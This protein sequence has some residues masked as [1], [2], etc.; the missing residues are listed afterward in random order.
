MRS[1]GFGGFGPARSRFLP[2]RPTLAPE[3]VFGADRLAGDDD[4]FQARGD[5]LD[6]PR[7]ARD[8]ERVVLPSVS[9][10][11]ADAR[12]QLSLCPPGALALSIG[13]SSPNLLVAGA[14]G[15]GKTYRLMVPLWHQ[16]VRSGSTVVIVNTKGPPFT[17][18]L[19]AIARSA[20]RE[21]T[22]LSFTDPARSVR[23]NPLRACTTVEKARTVAMALCL[24]HDGSREG[25]DSRF[26]IE[27]TIEVITSASL[28]LR[29]TNP[30][31]S[32]IDLRRMIGTGDF[33]SLAETGRKRGLDTSGLDGYIAFGDTGSHNAATCQADLSYRT[34]CLDQES[35]RA[36]LGG[37]ELSLAR[38]VRK[39]GLLIVEIDEQRVPML[40]P[41]TGMFV[42]LL[43]DAVFTHASR[44]PGG[45]LA[46][47]LYVMLNELPALGRVPYLGRYLNTAR[48]RGVRVIAD[49][50]SLSQLTDR[51]GGEAETVL[52]GF[53]NLIALG[54]GLDEPTAT[55]VSRRSGTT[56]VRVPG[57]M[58]TIDP[59]L[60]K[61]TDATKTWSVQGRPL[62]LPSEIARPGAYPG[63][64]HPATV[65]PGDGT[66]PFYAFF[67]LAYLQPELA[68]L[69]ASADRDPEP[70]RPPRRERPARARPTPAPSA[71][72]PDVAAA[73]AE[74]DAP[75]TDAPSADE[76]AGPPAMEAF[77][78]TLVHTT[79]SERDRAT[80]R[81]RPLTRRP[82]GWD[83]AD[84]ATRE[85]WDEVV[86]MH[87]LRR[88][89]LRQIVSVMRR[90]GIT[91]D[92]LVESIR[93]TG[94][95]HLGSSL[96]H[97]WYRVHR[98]LFEPADGAPMPDE[99]GPPVL[100][101]VPDAQ[102][103][104]IVDFRMGDD[105][106]DIPF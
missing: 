16:L 69:I 98:K 84:V 37:S 43:F 58:E 103:D 79:L 32:L 99:N 91:L 94:V 3:M 11:V 88:R 39:G 33:R 17:R 82:P 106:D 74:P 5:L 80:D 67:P 38:F 56:S 59:T 1:D 29:R 42:G 45:R 52:A 100:P 90:Q 50:Q 53:Q 64:G 104:G 15:A 92:D 27:K 6:A 62:L 73:P 26:W 51:Y 44:M 13:W 96:L 83:R 2:R 30:R 47:A 61:P 63:L 24:S 49:A 4:L 28:V 78:E 95:M 34:S 40:E 76:D 31:A 77:I 89:E 12:G 86:Q 75:P 101:E 54:G 55:Y 85:W 87:A 70:P 71:T 22:V 7:E 20:G 9:T 93:Q 81:D 21:C 23:W 105:C 57:G 14:A 66:P 25:S 18:R 10:V 72:S 19:R 8:G 36:V 48:E 41:V 102:V 65:L 68:E 97:A 35:L 46:S 60:A